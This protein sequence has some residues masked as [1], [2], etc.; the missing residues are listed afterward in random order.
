[1]A[2]EGLGGI[3]IAAVTVPFVTSMAP[4]EAAKA[5]GAPVE[6]DVGGIALGKMATVEWRGRPAWVLHRTEAMLASLNNHTS[7]LVDPDLSQPMEPPYAETPT[8]AIKPPY[9]VVTGICT[10]LGCVPLYRP[11]PGGVELGPD[12]PGGFYCPCHGSKFDLAGRVFENVP[13]PLNMEVPPHQYLSDTL[14]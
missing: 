4:S 1:V 12:W 13:A 14:L 5:A 7:L 10:H 2:T 6:A 3:G 11:E 9:F 8:R